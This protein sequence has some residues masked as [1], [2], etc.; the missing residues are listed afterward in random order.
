MYSMIMTNVDLSFYPSTAFEATDMSDS[1]NTKI[2]NS[3]FPF[4]GCEFV[5]HHRRACGRS[6]ASCAV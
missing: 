3:Y 1:A 4:R 6:D 5:G 2:Y